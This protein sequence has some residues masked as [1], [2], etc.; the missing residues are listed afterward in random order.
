M[1]CS[2]GLCG[3]GGGEEDAENLGRFSRNELFFLA[4]VGRSA[5]ALVAW[6]K[7]EEVEALNA[8][9]RKLRFVSGETLLSLLS[10]FVTSTCSSDRFEKVQFLQRLL[11]GDVT[12]TL[13]DAQ[14]DDRF[15]SNEEI[16]EGLEGLETSLIVMTWDRLEGCL[17]IAGSADIVHI[18]WTD[19]LR[20]QLMASALRNMM[21]F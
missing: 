18:C 10:S 7:K 16:V 12:F 17:G 8:E 21:Y 19:L 5:V 6:V 14:C 1:N 13:G 2:V 9:V 15:E 4:N 3:L 11:D 20:F